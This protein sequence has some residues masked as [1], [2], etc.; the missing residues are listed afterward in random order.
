M[1]TIIAVAAALLCFV[2]ALASDYLETHYVRAVHS[3]NATRAARCS[4]AMWLV[5]VIGL[6]AVLEVGVWVV[7]PEG[8]GLYLGTLWAMHDASVSEARK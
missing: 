7:I 6:V 3:R 2:L 1:H 5:G 8:A 4:V